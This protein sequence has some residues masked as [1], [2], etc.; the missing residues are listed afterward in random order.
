[1]AVTGPVLGAAC[2]SIL[3]TKLGGYENTKSV[4]VMF[5]LSLLCATVSIPIPFIRNF[6][7]FIGFTWIFLFFGGAIMPSMT[8][9]MISSVYKG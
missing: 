6:P 9:V 5:I 1:M 3:I 8:G 2:G 4:L 7:M